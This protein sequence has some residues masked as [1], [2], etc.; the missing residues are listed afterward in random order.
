MKQ[1]VFCLKNIPKKVRAA[2]SETV[3]P[4][5]VWLAAQKVLS[6]L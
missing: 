2:C 1:T 4:E 6:K 5:N 3:I